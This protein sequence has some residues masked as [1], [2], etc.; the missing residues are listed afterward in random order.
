[1]SRASS[2]GWSNEF[3]QPVQAQDL[4]PDS[5]HGYPPPPPF[6]HNWDTPNRASARHSLNP[7]KAHRAGPA[8]PP[9]G[10]R[11]RLTPAISVTS[12][13]N[14]P[15]ARTGALPARDSTV[16]STRE[17][18]TY[19]PM[20]SP[21]E[22]EAAFGDGDGLGVYQPQSHSDCYFPTQAQGNE[23]HANSYYS[24][25]SQD[26]EGHTDSY[27]SFQP[28]VH[29]SRADSYFSSQTH[30]H[31]GQHD[32][33]FSSQMYDN[34]ER[35]APQTR[36]QLFPL[37]DHDLMSAEQA[38]TAVAAAASSRA[39]DTLFIQRGVEME[40]EN[41]RSSS[42]YGDEE[43]GIEQSREGLVGEMGEEFAR[44]RM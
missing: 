42:Y 1:M 26:N 39:R 34:D 16:L 6:Y 12:P 21:Y 11:P 25:Q 9:I 3:P 33:Y 28:Q 29:E 4:N 36:A 38:A 40:G 19:Y 32:S 31:G 14:A 7:T 37:L 10:S 15:P 17:Q 13:P 30:D 20:M 18:F 41:Q 24:S 23:G 35:Q 43:D 27:F 2:P 8:G 22:A 44:M 5:P